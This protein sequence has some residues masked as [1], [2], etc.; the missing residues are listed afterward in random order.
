MDP[1]LLTKRPLPHRNS[2]LRLLPLSQQIFVHDLQQSGRKEIS[3]GSLSLSCTRLFL[4]SKQGHSSIPTVPTCPFFIREGG[5]HYVLTDFLSESPKNNLALRKPRG[6][7]S[8]CTPQLLR[9]HQM[10]GALPFACTCI[11]AP[12]L[13]RLLY[14]HS[15]VELSFISVVKT[16][17]PLPQQIRSARFDPLYIIAFPFP[18]L[19]SPLKSHN[20]HF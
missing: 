8:V 1:G 11:P 17:S 20:C 19:S 14:L 10:C 3:P 12:R 5:K 4:S 6:C 16:A 9:C 15:T 7:Y 18:F 13:V 2:L